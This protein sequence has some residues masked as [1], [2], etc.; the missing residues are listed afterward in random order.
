VSGVSR[1]FAIRGPNLM[2]LDPGDWLD[3]ADRAALHAALT[4]SEQDVAAGRLIALTRP[5][6]SRS[7]A[8]VEGASRPLHR[9]PAHVDQERIRWLENRDYRDL[10]ATELETATQ[11]LAV[12]PGAGTPKS[13]RM[14]PGKRVATQLDAARSPL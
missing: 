6:C 14:T 2:P 13:V 5:T 3:E 8:R 1:H 12:L 4:D 11:V 10:F 9:K 7:S